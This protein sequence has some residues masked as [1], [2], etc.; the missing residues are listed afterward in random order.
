MK[1]LRMALALGAAFFLVGCGDSGSFIKIGQK[2]FLIDLAEHMPFPNDLLFLPTAQE[3][4]DGTLNIPYDPQSP[5]APMMRSLN[6]LD[7]FSTISPIVIPVDTVIDP[8]S[9]YGN[10]KIYRVGYTHVPNSALPIATKLQEELKIDKDFQVITKDKQLVILPLKPL[11]GDSE[12]VVVIK[13]GVIDING[14]KLTPDKV[15]YLLYTEEPLFDKSGAPLH[16]LAPQ[17]LQKIAALRPYYHKLLAAIGMQ[18]KSVAAIF[19]FKTQTIG[20]VAKLLTDKNYD[21]KLLLQDSGHTSKD[22]LALGGADVSTL[23]GNAEV[24]V[25]KLTNIPYYLGIP[26]QNDP[27]APLHVQM[28]FDNGEPKESVKLTIPVLASIPK[29]CSMPQ[30]GWPVVIFQHGITQNRT[31]LLAVAESFANICSAAVAIDLPLHGITDKN[32]PLY[33][34]ALERTFNVD[35]FTEDEE[36]NVLAA[37]PDGEID[38]SGSHYINLA[39]PA[40]SRD[41]MRQSVAD[42]A[43]L[44][45]ALGNSVGVKFDTSKI[46]YVG[47]SLGAMVPFGYMANKSFDTAVLANPGG[48]IIQLL[49]NSQT[50]GPIL[51]NALAANGIVPGSPEYDKYTLVSQTLIDDADPINYAKSVGQKQKSLVFEVENDAVIPN[52]VISAPLSGTEP[53]LAAMGA[54][55]LPLDTAPGFVRVPDKVVY[56]KFVAGTHSSLLRPDEP[57]VTIEM[58]RQM[59]SFIASKGAGVKVEDI[60][61]LS[62]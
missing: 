40:I 33:M 48:G 60:G 28:Q 42:I 55:P 47:H 20:K 23:Q 32:S 31:N 19:G 26:S 4:A 15:G 61:L 30:N 22:L 1:N 45:H 13:R 56:A 49:M 29:S 46:S 25:G 39:N 21:S 43:A 14:A 53:L 51:Q 27:V 9:L 12:Y 34:G 17:T 10:L 50:F 35:Y 24:Y 6:M 18:G 57:S 7:G 3:R 54:K 8:S 52:S 44:V 5:S 41:N 16:G 37:Q 2:H 59:A 38:C 11:Q 62:E 58:Q 36:C